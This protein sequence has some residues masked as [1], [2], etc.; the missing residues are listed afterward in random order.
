MFPSY[1]AN[2]FLHFEPIGYTYE[3]SQQLHHDP[4]DVAKAMYEAAMAKHLNPFGDDK[5]D[6][7]PYVPATKTKTPTAAPSLQTPPYITSADETVR[8]RQEFVYYRV[9]RKE[10]L[11]PT[12]TL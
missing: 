6:E 3:I 8:W 10:K 11:K 9:D 5:D 1:F 2:V 7:N 4:S 12:K